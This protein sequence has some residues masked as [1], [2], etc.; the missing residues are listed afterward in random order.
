MRE[1]RRVAVFPVRVLSIC[2]VAVLLPGGKYWG[3]WAFVGGEIY[4]AGLAICSYSKGKS[5]DHSVFPLAGYAHT[6]NMSRSV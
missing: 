6:F 1:A 5:A 4:C 3:L 2:S